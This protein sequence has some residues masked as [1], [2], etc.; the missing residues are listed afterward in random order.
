MKQ[1]MEQEIEDLRNENMQLLKEIIQD[2]KEMQE[3]LD[4]IL[5]RK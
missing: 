3:M 1:S 2:V 4:K 5:K